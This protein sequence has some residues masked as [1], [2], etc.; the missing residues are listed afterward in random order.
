MPDKWNSI[1]QILKL[2]MLHYPWNTLNNFKNIVHTTFKV[3]RLSLSFYL[4]ASLLNNHKSYAFARLQTYYKRIGNGTE[5]QY[6]HLW[7]NKRSHY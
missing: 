3:I 6:K 2:Q 5:E 7:Q 4:D 1:Y